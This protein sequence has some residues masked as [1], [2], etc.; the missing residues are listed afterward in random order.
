MTA[1]PILTPK[2]IGGLRLARAAD[3]APTVNLLVYGEPG[4]G[5]TRLCGSA[6]AV[7]AMR[8]VLILDIDGGALSI[9]DVYPQVDVV[10]ITQFGEIWRVYQDLAS[11]H[12]HGYQTV[13]LDTG[14]EAQKYSMADI[15]NRVVMQAKEKGEYRDPE[16][17][18]VRE[19]GITTE[20]VRRMVRA[21]RDLPMNFLMTCHVKDDKDERTLITKKNPDLPGKLARQVAGF[22]DV[23]LYMY[24]LSRKEGDDV[25]EQRVLL[26]AATERV[27]AKD[28]TDKLPRHVTDISM[29]FVYNTLTGAK[30]ND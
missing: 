1:P 29:Q 2:S 8:K 14:T 12:N 11:G 5:K 6:D 20:Q 27:T 23:V 24:V 10:R 17:P 13:C 26:S 15:M 25:I 3:L 28:R 30:S 4:V 7:P 21:F 19:W 9:R 18:S 22:F 16:V